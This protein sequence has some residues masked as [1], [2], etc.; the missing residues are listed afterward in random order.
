[1]KIGFPRAIEIPKNPAKPIPKL[2]TNATQSS[3]VVCM[4]G[5]RVPAL[6][7]A[8]AKMSKTK[9]SNK[10]VPNVET[11]SIVKTLFRRS[12]GKTT[13]SKK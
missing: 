2:L 13:I 11:S 6:K 8:G 12:F 4:R 5:S 9:R 10:K 1:M 3:I 7:M